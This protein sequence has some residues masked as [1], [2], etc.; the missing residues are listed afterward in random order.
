MGK[1]SKAE[2]IQSVKQQFFLT[3]IF[4]FSFSEQKKVETLFN[5]LITTKKDKR[6]GKV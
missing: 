5:L 2:Q 1:N 4:L 6:N 3:K